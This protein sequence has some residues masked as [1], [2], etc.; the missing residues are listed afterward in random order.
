MPENRKKGKGMEPGYP[1]ARIGLW[2]KFIYLISGRTLVV[3]K[4]PI[5]QAKRP[6]GKRVCDLWI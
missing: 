3:E 5:F 2:T 6:K 1:K 4:L